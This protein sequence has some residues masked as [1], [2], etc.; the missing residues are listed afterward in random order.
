MT[1]QLDY[2]SITDSPADAGKRI[3]TVSSDQVRPLTAGGGAQEVATVVVDNAVNDT[4]YAYT[5][6]GV[7]VTITS[8]GSATKPEIAD[9][10]ADQHNSL[11][12]A[13]SFGIAVS[14]GVDTVTITARQVN[15][16]SGAVDGDANLTT[17]VTTAASAGTAVPF[18]VGVVQTNFGIGGLPSLG[19]AQVLD[20]VPLAVN[21]ALYNIT[22]VV[23]ADDDGIPETYNV[24]Y[25]GDA[26]ATV[27]EIVA[28]LVLAGNLLLPANSVLFADDAT[29]SVTLT[30][31]VAG[32]PF[33][34]TG[35]GSLPGA[36]ITITTTTANSRDPF[37]GVALKTQMVEG[38][39][40]GAEYAADDEMN[41]M[42]NGD[43][44]VVLDAGQNPLNGE[45]V[46]M[47]AVASGSEVL[48]AFRTDADGTDAIVLPNCTWTQGLE[49]ALDGST[50]IAGLKIRLN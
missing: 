14:D 2:G 32:K 29:A 46:F 49:T 22:I 50:L 48:G 8:D 34:A 17:T 16:A 21:L 42:E 13:A 40:T 23:D 10:L 33:E 25:Q 7:V 5:Y 27:P 24:P 6:N 39:S 45:A 1:Q 37:A 44:W 19:T 26:S 35:G 31:E 11:T 38:T 15:D 41:V 3:G 43:A 20:A 36:D 4:A 47:R 30:S 28:G 12:D 9:A 18:G